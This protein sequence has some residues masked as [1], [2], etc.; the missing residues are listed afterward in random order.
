[1][2]R[3]VDKAKVYAYMW[4]KVDICSSSI[5]WYAIEAPTVIPIHWK[6]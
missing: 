4:S 6:I 5:G 1:M 2:A 3:L